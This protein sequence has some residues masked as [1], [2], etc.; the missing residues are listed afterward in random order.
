[1]AHIVDTCGWLEFFADS[2][3]AKNFEKQILDVKQLFVPTIV[4]YEVYKKVCLEFDE[5]KAL[6][7]IAHMKQAKVV[8][9]TEPIA[10]Y[11]SKLSLE[12]KLPMADAIIYA[13]G[14]TYEAT[15][16]TQDNHFEGLSGV[17]YFKKL[18]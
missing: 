2:K 8:D 11:A 5:D 10:I 9:I 17:K 16:Y 3:N 13:T 7:V 6:L 12:K 18:K 1:M 14:L 4:I 15:V